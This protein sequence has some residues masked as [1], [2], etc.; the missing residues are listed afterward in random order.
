MLA[1]V[2]VGA[3]QEGEVAGGGAVGQVPDHGDLL[4]LIHDVGIG[5]AIGPNHLQYVGIFGVQEVFS[6]F[7]K[8]ILCS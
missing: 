4:L 7:R 6:V 8:L 3:V 5:V 2:D 1:A